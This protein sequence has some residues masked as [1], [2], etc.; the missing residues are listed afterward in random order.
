MKYC[1][2]FH[3]HSLQKGNYLAK[4]LSVQYHFC[5]TQFSFDYL[6]YNICV[7]KLKNLHQ[8]CCQSYWQ[9]S[10]SKDL[11]LFPIIASEIRHYLHW[12]KS[13]LLWIAWLDNKVINRLES[14]LYFAFHHVCQQ[15]NWVMEKCV[16]A[17]SGTGSSQINAVSFAW[18]WPALS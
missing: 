3:S 16:G 15:P 2:V 4:Q 6:S 13:N 7:M 8:S 1:W 14:H 10:T 17:D 18:W 12:I 5:K 9:Y 11:R